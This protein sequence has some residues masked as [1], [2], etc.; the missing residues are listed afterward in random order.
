MAYSTMR[1]LPCIL[2]LVSLV[3]PLS[4]TTAQED[5]PCFS[6]TP[7]AS[8]EHFTPDM[9]LD[10]G[11]ALG[12]TA[13]CTLSSSICLEITARTGST[14]EAYDLVGRTAHLAV[15]HS[16]Y[17]LQADYRVVHI[18]QIADLSATAGLGFSR[19]ST[20]EQLVSL[21]VLGQMTIPGRTE[22]RANT[23][24]GLIVSKA[25]SSSVAL[26]LEPQLVLL[27]P[28]SEHQSLYLIS[29]G[30]TFVLF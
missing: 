20:D 12:V 28:F 5:L 14:G 25:F 10:A 27:S 13:T 29:G 21:G 1:K 22:T 15:R 18:D 2:L 24:V 17:Q 23:S 4:V 8:F 7:F 3:V 26:R 6:L 9:H 11:L 19:L 16:M 30:I